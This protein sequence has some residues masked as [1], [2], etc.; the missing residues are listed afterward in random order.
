LESNAVITK[1]DEYNILKRWLGD[2]L[3]ISSGEK[4]KSR[5]KLL[6]PSFHFNVLHRFQAIFDK[7]SKVCIIALLGSL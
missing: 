1:G 3:L 5:R 4:W 7:E 2:G 6:T